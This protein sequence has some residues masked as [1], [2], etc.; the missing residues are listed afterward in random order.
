MILRFACLAAVLLVSGLAFA[1]EQKIGFVDSGKIAEI[2]PQATQALERLESEFSSRETE[3]REF[4]AELRS[5]EAELDKNAPIMTQSDIDRAQLEISAMRR[6]LNR[7]QQDFKDELNLRRNQELTKL[8]RIVT[9]AIIQ[10][11]KEEGFDLI[12]EQAV[13][14]NDSVDITERVLEKLRK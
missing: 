4:R 13:Y 5:A 9:E 8:Q 10:I 12:V 14:W 2:A 6:K 11:A 7:L 1:E 3:I